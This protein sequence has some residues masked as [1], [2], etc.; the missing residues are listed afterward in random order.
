MITP[1]ICGVTLV[2]IGTLFSVQAFAQFNGHTLR[3]DFGLATRST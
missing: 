2:L 1:R 3:G